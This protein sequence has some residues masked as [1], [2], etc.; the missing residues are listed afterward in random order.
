M[1]FDPV[2]EYAINLRTIPVIGEAVL[3]DDVF[4]FCWFERFGVHPGDGGSGWLGGVKCLFE[5]FV[6]LER[7]EHPTF[8]LESFALVSEFDCCGSDRFCD[9][10]GSV[11]MGEMLDFASSSFSLQLGW[12]LVEPNTIIS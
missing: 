1:H 10:G 11:I 9:D 6:V 4:S 8:A 5:G 12:W 7:Y 2:I 3:H